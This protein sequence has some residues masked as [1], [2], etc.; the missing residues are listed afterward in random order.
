M[1]VVN[2]S[3]TDWYGGELQSPHLLTADRATADIYYASF[4][5]DVYVRSN[6][7]ST[8]T[9]YS[10]S[11]CFGSGGAA[12]IQAMPSNAGCAFICGGASVLSGGVDTSN[13]FYRS[14]SGGPTWSN[15]S[16]GSYTIH[17]VYTF[18]F[19]ACSKALTT[20]RR[21]GAGHFTGS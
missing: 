15:V 7:G 20:A 10:P 6:T 13:D 5:T 11:F 12:Q 8:W 19:G 1:S 3:G 21:G 2:P 14:T 16:N 9:A 18:G 4:G 17:E